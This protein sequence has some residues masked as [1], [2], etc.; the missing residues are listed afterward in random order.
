MKKWIVVVAALL[1]YQK[2]DV[3]NRFVY[4]LPD[5]AAEHGGKVIIYGT[6]WCGYCT[7]AR[8]LL[9]KNAIAFYEYDIEKSRIGRE[10]FQRLGGNGTPLLLI[11]GE[12]VKGYNPARI[13]ALAQ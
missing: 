1:I 5:Y 11:N 6:A 2:W 3:I 10:Q 9:N 4:P 12:V 8:N 7:Q 13:L